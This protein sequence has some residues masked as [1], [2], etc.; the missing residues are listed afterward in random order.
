MGMNLTSGVILS[1]SSSD[2]IG[3]VIDTQFINYIFIPDY[4]CL[5]VTNLHVVLLY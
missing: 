3:Q 4:M 1:I 5:F 2:A